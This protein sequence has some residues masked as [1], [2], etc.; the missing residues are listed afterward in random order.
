MK[1]HPRQSAATVR[2]TANATLRL[3][4]LIEP[5]EP[6]LSHSHRGKLC[7]AMMTIKFHVLLESE[8][9]VAVGS[10]AVLGGGFGMQSFTNQLST[11][12]AY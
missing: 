2:P 6:K 8:G 9:T 3:T 5:N 7:N 12:S 10:S 4:V 11:L 1:G